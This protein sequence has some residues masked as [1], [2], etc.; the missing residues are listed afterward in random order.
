[1]I[2]S[3]SS[4]IAVDIHVTH[5]SATLLYNENDVDIMII[6]EILGHSCI[7]ATEIYTHISSEKMKYIMENCTIS[8]FINIEEEN[9][10]G[11]K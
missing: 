8:N 4:K 5:T 7:S 9:K 2:Y 1:M 11:N 10:D 6:K 3:T